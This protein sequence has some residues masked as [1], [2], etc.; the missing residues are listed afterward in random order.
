[1]NVQI[2]Y[3]LKH[4]AFLGKCQLG[5]TCAYLYSMELTEERIR[6]RRKQPAP[7]DKREVNSM[8]NEAGRREKKEEKKGE[9]PNRN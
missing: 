6:E 4:L 2:N 7:A 1:M 8:R 5:P 3:V 9:Q